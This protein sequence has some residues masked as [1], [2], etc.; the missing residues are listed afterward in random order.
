MHVL[1][2]SLVLVQQ[3]GLGA[4]WASGG[5][6]LCAMPTCPSLLQFPCSQSFQDYM[7]ALKGGPAELAAACNA[8]QPQCTGF[9]ATSGAL[10][11]S[12]SSAANNADSGS[13]PKAAANQIGILKGSAVLAPHQLSYSPFQIAFL[14]T[15]RVRL[16]PLNASDYPAGQLPGSNRS[17]T[18][19]VLM[20]PQAELRSTAYGGL[21]FNQEAADAA[22]CTL[23]CCAGN[24]LLWLCLSSAGC[25]IAAPNIMLPGSQVVSLS[26]ETAFDA[27]TKRCSLHPECRCESPTCCVQSVW[28]AHG[29][30]ATLSHGSI[31]ACLQPSTGAP[32]VKR[33]AASSARMVSSHVAF[34]LV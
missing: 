32:P 13:S 3:L 15:G 20:R 19:N 25:V 1:W 2:A 10:T 22:D 31:S 12:G 24:R 4:C 14:Q 28:L 16:V 34:S 17:A 11:T 33:A 30:H 9:A 6:T 27:C 18:F 23:I 7:C 26:V 21:G 29:P 8:A 5:A